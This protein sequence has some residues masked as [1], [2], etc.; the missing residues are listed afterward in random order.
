[1]KG[2]EEA[3]SFSKVSSTVTFDGVLS[4]KLTFENMAS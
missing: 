4:S 1:M 2:M 3:H